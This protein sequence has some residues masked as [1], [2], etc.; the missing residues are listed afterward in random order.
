M[1]VGLRELGVVVQSTKY[2][3]CPSVC[4]IR[5]PT[6]NARRSAWTGWCGGWAHPCVCA[7]PRRQPSAEPPR[8]P[9]GAATLERRFGNYFI[10]NRNISIKTFNHLDIWIFQ[11]LPSQVFQIFENILPSQHFKSLNIIGIPLCRE[12]LTSQ[13]ICTPLSL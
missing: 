7:H 12:A 6:W 11:I 9:L 10:K 5:F 2:Y 1:P 8:Q 3:K 13:D 4:L